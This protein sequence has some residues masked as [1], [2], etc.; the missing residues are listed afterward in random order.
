MANGTFALFSFPAEHFLNVLDCGLPSIPHSFLLL[1]PFSVYKLFAW[2]KFAFMSQLSRKHLI[3]SV[4]TIWK[5]IWLSLTTFTPPIV[6]PILPSLFEIYLLF[7][8]S[9]LPKAKTLYINHKS[10]CFLLTKLSA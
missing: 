2:V 9:S 7:R 10:L 6:S 4:F 3:L 5:G 1:L 8:E